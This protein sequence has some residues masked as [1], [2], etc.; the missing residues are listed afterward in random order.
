MVHPERG[1]MTATPLTT[2]PPRSQLVAP[3]DGA[4]LSRGEQR[5][6]G[7]A[8]S[9]GASVERVEVSVDDGRTWRA[10]EWASEPARYAPRARD[11]RWG[12]TSPGPAT[13]R[14]RS[15]QARG[16]TPPATAGREPLC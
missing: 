5:L 2:I 6:R 10:A 7:L 16:R 9:G 8:W 15:L 14:S 4:R 12:A 1:D 13:R 11:D 3:S